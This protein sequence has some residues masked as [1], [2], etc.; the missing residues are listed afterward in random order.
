MPRQG[1]SRA[2]LTVALLARAGSQAAPP[3][4]RDGRPNIILIILDTVRAD[5]VGPR[6]DGTTLTPFLDSW[7]R[8]GLRFTRAMSPADVTPPSHFSM[9]TGLP[10]GLIGTSADTP[11]ASVVAELNEAGYDT[12]GLS[13]NPAVDPAA[14]SSAKPFQTFRSSPYLTHTPIR[15]EVYETYVRHRLASNVV[16]GLDVPLA[17][18]LASAD[19][20]NL[21]LEEVLSGC[22]PAGSRRPVFLFMNFFDVHDPYV[23]PPPFA[24]SAERLWKEWPVN[25][26]IRHFPVQGRN[27]RGLRAVSPYMYADNYEPGQLRF[28]VSLY[29]RQVQYL[30]SRLRNTFETLRRHHLLEN[31]VVVVTADHGEALGEEGFLAHGLGGFLEKPFEVP[32]LI[33]GYGRRLRPAGSL[34]ARTQ[35][36]RITDSIRA[37]ASLDVSPPQ[38]F[39][40][41]FNLDPLATLERPAVLPYRPQPVV[42]KRPAEPGTD[43][44]EPAPEQAKRDA[45]LAR[46]LRSLG[47]LN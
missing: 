22:E 35:T 9:F 41:S 18:T 20:M 44:K 21:R 7:A 46:R 27:P 43:R 33:R 13:A 24:V 30:D 5:R 29:D 28:L 10:G 17:V 11:E 2:L 4:P 36:V 32:L 38:A 3:P 37:W 14:L 12:I 39:R 6:K 15:A 26:D 47:Y 1:I 23:P 8:G 42:Q 34:A 45:E 25:G 16:D 19:E 31:A 40:R